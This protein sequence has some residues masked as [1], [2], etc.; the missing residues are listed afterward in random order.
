MS[1]EKHYLQ[2]EDRDGKIHE[3]QVPAMFEGLKFAGITSACSHGSATRLVWA[4]PDGTRPSIEM[5]EDYDPTAGWKLGGYRREAEEPPVVFPGPPILLP[6]PRSKELAANAESLS[7]EQM[8]RNLL[9]MA[10]EEG[11]VDGMPEHP[12]SLTAGDITGTANLLNE[13]LNPQ[14][15]WISVNDKL[16]PIGKEVLVL[17]L[18]RMQVMSLRE[19]W[20]ITSLNQQ[21]HVTGV[22]WY[23]GGL[24]IE[25][26]S[27]WMPLPAPPNRTE[28]EDK[29]ANGEMSQ[30]AELRYDIRADE[31]EDIP[32]ELAVLCR[33][34][35]HMRGWH[36]GDMGAL[37]VHGD[38][39][40]RCQCS[41]YM[42]KGEERE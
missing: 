22:S 13:Y 15:H 36:N 23:P 33:V 2:F 17:A 18:G 39:P 32:P 7:V 6:L 8:V 16:P 19:N 35:G 10:L 26:S 31:P 3:V 5:P 28:L 30:S 4:L 25:N 41:G 34:C 14:R 24:P 37:C 1:H 38:G 42:P 11:A 9:Q 20:G 29:L 21:M 40:E 12:Q 27:H